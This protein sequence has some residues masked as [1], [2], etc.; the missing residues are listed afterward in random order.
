MLCDCGEEKLALKYNSMGK[1]L[2][3]ADEGEERVSLKD[4]AAVAS[5]IEG[6]AGSRW[7]PV[8]LQPRRAPRVESRAPPEQ[9]LDHN[10]ISFLY[11]TYST[12]IVSLKSS[13]RR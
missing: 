3:S 2:R 1:R 4:Q 12:Y 11:H 8:H 7:F 5:V 13:Q 9:T 6:P 10:I